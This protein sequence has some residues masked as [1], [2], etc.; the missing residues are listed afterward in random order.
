MISKSF[1]ATIALA[2][3]I[4]APAVAADKY[5]V[6]AAHTSIGFS[7]SHMVIS[8]TKGHFKEFTSS[9]EFDSEKKVVTGVTTTIKAASIDTANAKRDEHLRSADFFDV[10]KFPEITFTAKSIEQKNGQWMA[11][12]TFT[13]HGVSKEIALPFRV[14]GPIKDPWGNERL[15]VEATITINRKDYGLTWSKTMETGGLVVG[16]E[17]EISISAEYVK[18]K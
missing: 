6:D 15:G 14:L 16:D 10:E 5:E 12:G 13:M 17:V 11:N 2:A 18:A 9:I 1:I 8:K 3:I 4:A 7:I